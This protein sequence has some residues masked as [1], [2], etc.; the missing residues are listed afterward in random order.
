[1]HQF[2]RDTG[3]VD[4]VSDEDFVKGVGCAMP[5]DDPRLL[6]RFHQL[7]LYIFGGLLLATALI[8]AAAILAWELHGLVSL[9]RW[10]WNR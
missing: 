10:L 5:L 6:F 4:P 8:G 7:H 9:I 3:A 2:V 1:M